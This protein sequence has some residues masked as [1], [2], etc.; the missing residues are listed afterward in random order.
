VLYKGLVELAILPPVSLYYVMR[1]HDYL[2]NVPHLKVLNFGGSVDRGI[3][4]RM[5]LDQPKPLVKMLTEVYGVK[6]AIDESVVPEKIVPSR[7]DE[8]PP[9]TRIVLEL[10][11]SPFKDQT[12]DLKQ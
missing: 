2:S 6:K 12:T 7:K 8:N 4:I 3:T 11:E 9:V 5:N 10:P 1:L